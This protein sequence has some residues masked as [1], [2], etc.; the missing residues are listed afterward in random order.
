MRWYQVMYELP[1]APGLRSRKKPATNPKKRSVA[2]AKPRN[3]GE[4]RE[5]SGR[6]SAA[7]RSYTLQDGLQTEELVSACVPAPLPPL[8]SL[9]GGAAL[10]PVRPRALKAP[11]TPA[12]ST[13]LV[14]PLAYALIAGP[15]VPAAATM[16]I[17]AIYTNVC[18]DAVPDSLLGDL[19]QQLA[20]ATG[21]P[22]QVRAGGGA[23]PRW[24]RGE[25]VRGGGSA[26]PAGGEA[27]AGRAWDI[28]APSPP[29]AGGLRPPR[30]SSCG[31]TRR[32]PRCSGG[33]S[34]CPFHPAAQSLPM[35][36]PSLEQQPGLQERG[37]HVA[38]DVL[39]LCWRSG[40][41][42]RSRAVARTRPGRGSDRPIAPGSSRRFSHP[43]RPL[44]PHRSGLR[45]RSPIRPNR[46]RALR[47]ALRLGP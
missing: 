14:P 43:T 39:R 35:L 6:E 16:P 27:L 31:T 11:P 47:Q 18:K 4:A 15:A 17:F 25:H 42:Q 41:E 37:A 5:T 45:S 26:S 7:R 44:E 33:R 12:R 46:C 38:G 24:K 28:S 3:N 2:A 13:V 21:K 10:R 20:K 22:A 32:R 9:P 30:G 1:S 19:T 36:G 29:G 8:P 23:G 40:F 34:L